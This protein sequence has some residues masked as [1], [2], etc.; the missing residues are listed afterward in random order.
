MGHEGKTAMSSEL[1]ERRR[2]LLIMLCLALV[3]AAL[4]SR[5]LRVGLMSDDFMQQGMIDGLYPGSG[6]VPFDLYAFLRRGETMV[7]HVE[8][9]TAPWWAVPEL[10]GTVLRP[11]A[12]LLLWLDRTLLPGQFVLWHLHSMLWFVAA[13][14]A[15]GVVARRLLPR[16]MALLAVA[17]FVCEAGLVSP[18]SWLANRCV[19]ICASFGF[20]GLWAHIEWRAPREHTPAWLRRHGGLVVAAAMTGAIAAGEY[21][22][23]VFAYLVAWELFAGEGSATRRLRALLPA[24]APVLV[25]LAAHKLL[26]YGTFGAEVYADPVHAPRGY[27]EW[28]AKRVPKLIAAGFWSIPGA[29]IHVYRFGLTKHLDQRWH[30]SDPSMDAYHR[31]HVQLALIGVALA[32]VALVLARRAWS[33]EE[34]RSLRVLGVGGFLGL[35]PIAV[36]PAHSRLLV[37]AQLA[38][39]TLVAAVLVACVRL[40]R[41]P[42]SETKSNDRPRR[43]WP[44]YLRGAALVPLAGLLA[45]QHTIGDLRWGGAFLRHLDELQAA[46]I[47]CFT[48]GDLLEHELGGRDVVILNGPSQSV[49]LFGAFVLHVHGW[50]T[51]RSWRPLAL[52]S[53]FAMVATRPRPDTLVL[54]AIQ[55]S[56]LHTAGEL[57]FRRADQPLR[58]GDVLRY[59]SLEVEILADDDGHPTQVRFHFDRPLDDPS[60]IFVTATRRGLN[61]WQVPPV[62]GR[63]VVPLPRLPEVSD[64]EAVHFPSRPGAARAE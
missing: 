1:R 52:G 60:L 59:P 20:M 6:Y 22:L 28:A 9:G 46:N 10:H 44:A 38:M 57:F 17:L 26:G 53:E 33:T 27:L 2:D 5:A 42:R 63:N 19:L 48:E 12:S 23:A 62:G 51:P 8:L 64:P 34:R 31:A 15:L 40:L 54:A 3:G 58:T 32:A 49:G 45:W 56:W 14:V 16:S 18:L 29:T 39:C 47:A 24:L 13:S 30:P 11:L 21:G 43:A 4:R 36:A 7:A 25:Y 55:G 41:R 37:I 50:D 35:L 61:R